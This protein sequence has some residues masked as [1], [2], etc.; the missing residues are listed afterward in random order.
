MAELYYDP[1]DVE[2]DVDPYPTYRRL[3]EEAP[4]YYNERLDFWAL[5]RFADVE[6]ALK[7]TSRLSSA[8]G[9]ILE[10]VKAD[11]VMPP[12]VFINEDPP[13]HTMH[14]ALVSR[15]FT[16][17]RMK[18]LE[19]QIRAFCAACLDPL[20]G[21]ERFDFVLDLGAQMRVVKAMARLAQHP[22][23]RQAQSKRHH[24][25]ETANHADRHLIMAAAAKRRH[26]FAG[27]IVAPGQADMPF[28]RVTVAQQPDPADHTRQAA[29]GKG[30]AR[31]AEEENPV[32]GGIAAGQPAIGRHDPRL[33]PAPQRPAPYVAGLFILGTLRDESRQ[34]GV[35]RIRFDFADRVKLPIDIKTIV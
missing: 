24:R 16:P 25:V 7:D 6:S 31:I 26:R 12:G 34:F 23:D 15:A 19:D 20:V 21:D 2:I 33:D 5:S 17:G 18:K 9:D 29:R 30:P 11:P 35:E 32:A 28:G 22:Q 13:E 1:Y 4:L 27:L 10:V 14:R 8:K 3:R